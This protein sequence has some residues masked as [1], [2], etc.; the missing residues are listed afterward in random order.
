VL[1]TAIVTMLNIFDSYL[2]SSISSQE[3]LRD[4]NRTDRK[5]LSRLVHII[6][7]LYRTDIASVQTAITQLLPLIHQPENAVLV[8]HD[9][10]MDILPTIKESFEITL[11]T[12]VF[13]EISSISD[14]VLRDLTIALS[15]L[16]IPQPNGIRICSKE[17]KFLPILFQIVATTYRPSHFLTEH[18]WNFIR[19][20]I[21]VILGNC[22][23]HVESHDYL[24]S[25][26]FAYFDL[27][28]DH[29]FANPDAPGEVSRF[30]SLTMNIADSSHMLTLVNMGIPEFIL[31]KLISF[32]SQRN[33]WDTDHWNMI[34]RCFCILLN[35]SLHPP[36]CPALRN[37]IESPN[38]G[39]LVLFDFFLQRNPNNSIKGTKTVM[40]LSNIYRDFVDD[41][42]VNASCLLKSSPYVVPMLLDVYEATLNY[43]DGKELI[44]RLKRKAFMFGRLSVKHITG[45]LK[46][47]AI[48]SDENKQMLFCHDRL[49]Y[50]IFATIQ[51]FIVDAE[52]CKGMIISTTGVTRSSTAGGG[53][54]DYES[55]ENVLEL[56]LQLSY[57][58]S[59][60]YPDVELRF[61]LSIPNSQWNVEL[62]LKQLL[63]L[64]K[65]RVVPEKSKQIVMLLLN[66]LSL[67]S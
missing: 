40:L 55:L 45:S 52:E 1:S 36:C 59:Q 33:G 3:C 14:Y 53:G 31:K 17:L 49:L 60:H 35:F 42:P 57:F 32:G 11:R 10:E 64:P 62:F 39:A 51:M 44:I 6:S 29:L 30:C 67:S 12:P 28:K 58:Y 65:T 66:L 8:C 56:L 41:S 19:N 37:L 16:A 22:S 61:I 5:N 63:M 20:E 43:S 13:G 15:W 23:V 26:E 18:V 27:C 54:K 48:I 50:L 21:R 25:P 2:S 9:P 7:S 38:I 24:F 34:D 46:N 47:F 4:E